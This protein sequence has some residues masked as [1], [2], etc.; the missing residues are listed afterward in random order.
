MKWINL[1]DRQPIT[2]DS[3]GK[4]HWRQLPSKTPFTF[5][6][7]D[8]K[9]VYSQRHKYTYQELEWLDE[10]EETPKGTRIEDTILKTENAFVISSFELLGKD[11]RGNLDLFKKFLEVFYPDE[12]RQLLAEQHSNTRH[13]I[14]DAIANSVGGQGDMYNAIAGYISDIIRKVPQRKP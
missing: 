3:W 6:Q 11:C 9:Y 2:N 13:D 12:T 4:L 10:S 5:L 8:E 1:A 7:M 14:L